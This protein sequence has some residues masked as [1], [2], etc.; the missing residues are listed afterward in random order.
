MID[1]PIKTE[2]M[3]MSKSTNLLVEDLHNSKQL[4]TV[5]YATEVEQMTDFVWFRDS[6]IRVNVALYNVNVV[7]VY[8][9]VQHQYSDNDFVVQHLDYIRPIFREATEKFCRF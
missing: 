7:P 2:E 3:R 5:F 1:I 4:E 9:D 6:G 8:S